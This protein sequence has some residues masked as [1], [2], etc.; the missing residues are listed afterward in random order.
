MWTTTLGAARDMLAA[1]TGT[2]PSVTFFMKPQQE[3]KAF[4]GMVFSR[5]QIDDIDGFMNGIPGVP[6]YPAWG[7]CV[8]IFTS[9]DTINLWGLLLLL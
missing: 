4:S 9:L 3:T 6:E 1:D 8:M 7:G 5:E 2:T